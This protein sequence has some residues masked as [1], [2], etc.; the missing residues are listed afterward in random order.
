M[1]GQGPQG[2]PGFEPARAQIVAIDG[3]RRGGEMTLQLHVQRPGQGTVEAWCR[4]QVPA[5]YAAALQVGQSVDVLVDLRDPRWVWLDLHDAGSSQ[6]DTTYQ[7][8]LQAYQQANA[9]VPDRAYV[10][11]G[12]Q[13]P[14]GYRPGQYPGQQYPGGAPFSGQLPPGAQVPLGGYPGGGYP[15]GGRGGYAPGG[16]NGDPRLMPVEGITYELFVQLSAEQLANPMPP[17]QFDQLAYSRGVAL[18]RW[19][20]I[21][22]EWNQRFGQFPD[23]GM[24]FQQDVQQAVGRMTGARGAPPPTAPQAPWG[25]GPAPGGYRP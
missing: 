11:P 9:Q 12:Q 3:D 22:G 19:P 5:S 7:D 21:Q 17:Q 18:G 23:L 4:Q 24:R 2:Q 20:T 25:P 10:P 1:S 13:L 16:W 14:P 6:R 8:Q 15:G